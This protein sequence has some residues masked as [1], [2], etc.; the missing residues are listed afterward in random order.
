MKSLK[1]RKN[2]KKSKNPKKRDL[3]R[4]KMNR[5]LDDNRIYVAFLFILGAVI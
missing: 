2:H 4:M 5:D 3:C 1:N